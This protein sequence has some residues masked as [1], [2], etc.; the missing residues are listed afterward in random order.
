MF[1]HNDQILTA[2]TYGRGIWR[3]KVHEPFPVIPPVDRSVAPDTPLAAGLMRDSSKPVPQL[4]TPA[5]GAQIHVFPRVTTLTWQP[6]PEAIG[7]TVDV[8]I[9][10]LS[11]SY[12]SQVPA[13]TFDPGTDGDGTWRVWAIFEDSR[14]SPGSETRSIKYAT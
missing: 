8:W 3:L 12:S 2:A 14:R 13:L 1:H 4:L 6:V 5:N 7:Y 9:S 11:Q 10:G